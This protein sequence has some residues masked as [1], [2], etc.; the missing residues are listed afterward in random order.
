M[1]SRRHIRQRRKLSVKGWRSCLTGVPAFLIGNGISLIDDVDPSLL[2]NRF[3]IGMNRCFQNKNGFRGIDPTILIWQD[4]EM[5]YTERMSLSRLKAIKYCRDKSDPQGKYYHFKLTSGPFKLPETAEK[6][7][8]RGS[9]GPLA[10][11]L[12][13]VMGCNPIV[14][15]GMDCKYRRGMTD[16]YGT[17]PHHKSHTLKDCSRGLLWVKQARSDRRI[18]NCSD[19]DVFDERLTL[20]EALRE[21]PST[22]PQNRE[23]LV[24]RILGS[25]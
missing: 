19:N 23:S 3:T 2:K 7:H 18:I 12:A 25:A 13:W 14:L 15:L 17:N 21:A 6:L 4:I 22:I 24:A 20:E 5:L 9:T 10:F 11:Q 16:F 8:G 1:R